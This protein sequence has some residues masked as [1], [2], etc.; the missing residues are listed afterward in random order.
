MGNPPPNHQAIPKECHLPD[1]SCQLLGQSTSRPPPRR[2]AAPPDPPP[3]DPAVWAQVGRSPPPAPHLRGPRASR[4]PKTAGVRHKRH[5][6]RPDSAKS[7][8]DREPASQKLWGSISSPANRRAPRKPPV[9]QAAPRAF[10]P[11]PDW[12]HSPPPPSPALPPSPEGH[13]PK[14]NKLSD[15]ST[16]TC[17]CFQLWGPA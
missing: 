6:R 3:P 17:I 1:P 14:N 16:F 8:P 7:S 9:A 5:K 10:V 4:K 2:T 12:H 13:V 15:M 11:G